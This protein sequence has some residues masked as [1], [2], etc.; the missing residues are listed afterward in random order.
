MDIL[1]VRDC[2]PL[3]FFK[4]FSLDVLPLICL[5]GTFDWS[6]DKAEN[7]SDNED[8]DFL[9]LID[10]VVGLGLLIGVY[11]DIFSISGI[12]SLRIDP[13]PFLSGG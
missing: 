1:F 8:S 7:L 2:A 9:R 4:T 12:F 11:S 3:N 10:K 5:S 13:I 6:I